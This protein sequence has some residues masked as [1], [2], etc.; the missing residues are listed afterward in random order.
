MTGVGDR[1]KPKP[2]SDMKMEP[3]SPDS[4]LAHYC[5]E[6][7][8]IVSADASPYGLGTVLLR[9]QP[10]KQW[11]PVAFHSRAL[12]ETE[13]IYA[14]IEKE[15]FA[16]TW[17]CECFNNYLVGKSFKIQ[18]DHKPLIP[19]LGSNDLNSLPP[20]IQIFQMHLMRFSFMI[21]HVP[22]K[23]LITADALSRS[24]LPDVMAADKQF[25]EDICFFVARKY[26]IDHVT[27]SPHYPQANGEAEIIVAT[28]KHIL[29][30][31]EDPYLAM[32]SY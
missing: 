11:R 8:T 7:D 24:P 15:A 17:P 31:S 23:D 3:S 20:H 5:A 21:E 9:K 28:M 4:I 27:S 18:M 26:G 6:R 10:D 19:L 22:G 13:Q 25:Q 32:L 1:N 30:K 14:Q 29:E 12:T 16:V 2:F